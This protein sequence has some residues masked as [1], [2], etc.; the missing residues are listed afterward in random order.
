MNDSHIT[1]DGIPLGEALALEKSKEVERHLRNE[2]AD[3]ATQCGL[4]R[5]PSKSHAHFGRPGRPRKAVSLPLLSELEPYLKDDACPLAD[6]A[7]LFKFSM[8]ELQF[9]M[10]RLELHRKRGRK[11]HQL[12]GRAA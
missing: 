1:I 5:C 11:P 2:I 12:Q 9:Y 3:I 10:R 6:I 7:D 8:G 4:K